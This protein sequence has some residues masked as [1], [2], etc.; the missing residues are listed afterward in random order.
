MIRQHDPT[1]RRPALGCPPGGGP[2]R[3]AFAGFTQGWA[4]VGA[5]MTIGLVDDWMLGAAYAGAAG[6]S[7]NGA[8]ESAI[9]RIAR[10][11]ARHTRFFAQEA[12]HRLAASPK[13][14]RLARQELRRTVWPLGSSPLTPADR[15]R[16]TC[17]AFGGD[18]GH[19]RAADLR[20]RIATLPG[21]DDRTAAIVWAGLAR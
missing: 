8:L 12:H 20:R 6:S 16:F 2:V 9:E 1:L 14:A 11:K 18:A 17:F 4:V 10:V 3:R 21:I 15:T 19:L 5:H 13:A 7:E